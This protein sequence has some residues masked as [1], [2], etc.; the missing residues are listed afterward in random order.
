MDQKIV[1]WGTIGCAGIAEGKFIPGLL[2]AKNAKLYA[3]S[4]RG[5]SAG[6]ERFQQKFHP[7][8]AYE[9]YNELLDDP[10]IDAVYVPLPNG[11]HAE[12]AIRAL[13]KKKNVLCEKP[14]GVTEAEVREMQA[15]S[16]KNGVLL[17]EA[18]AF[19]Q[20]PLT[21]KAKELVEAG[22]V[23]KVKFIEAHFCFNFKNENDVRFSTALAGGATYDVGCYNLNLIRYIAGEEP[24]GVLATG[25]VGA[26]SGVDE[27]SCIMLTFS[28][29]ITA[30]SYC[31]FGASSRSEYTILGE[32]GII[33]VP[34]EFNT[35][36]ETV[37]N[38][39]VTADGKTREVVIDTPNNY[40]LEAEQFSRAVLGE[41]K[42]LITFD[43]SI[44][45]AKVIDEALR[46]VFAKR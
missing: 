2:G 38:I 14:M 11:L 45:N 9:S 42:P 36:G 39:I 22:T 17:M 41:E 40:M 6:L 20:S 44:G 5:K 35:F 3:I 34:H 25:K 19:R 16:K 15:A 29:G 46:Q 32:E 43:D 33:H 27:E 26:K 1:N 21:L 23:G 24:A 4:S 7:V 37:T 31:S 28:N 13:E 30:V 12:W 8:K 18:F 10:E